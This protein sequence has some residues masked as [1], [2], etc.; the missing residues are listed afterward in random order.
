MP[1]FV[2]SR[3]YATEYTDVAKP[4][5]PIMRIIRAPKESTEK[6]NE[7]LYTPCDATDNAIKKE[8]TSTIAPERRE[9]ISKRILFL[10]KTRSND[11]ITNEE[12]REMR[13]IN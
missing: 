9:I 13:Y 12:K 5:H 6:N 4:I 10:I 1:F 7:E 11:V 2:S 3:K 8:C